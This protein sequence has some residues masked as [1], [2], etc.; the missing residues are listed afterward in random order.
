MIRRRLFARQYHETLANCDPNYNKT[1][2]EGQLRNGRNSV[3]T[4]MQLMTNWSRHILFMDIHRV[5]L[6]T[7]SKRSLYWPSKPRNLQKKSRKRLRK[8]NSE[9]K[10][11][12]TTGSSAPSW[13]KKATC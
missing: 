3:T 12:L 2:V 1:A 9:L 10:L 5:S 8:R 7:A 11:S 6:Q 4:M 13:S